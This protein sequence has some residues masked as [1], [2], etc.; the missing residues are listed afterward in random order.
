LIAPA[1]VAACSS[2]SSDE[3]RGQDPTPP[4]VAP[5]D[6]ASLATEGVCAQRRRCCAALGATPGF[7]KAR[8][9]CAMQSL[10]DRMG[11]DIPMDSNAFTNI[12]A[13]QLVQLQQIWK[14]HAIGDAGP[15]A[16]LPEACQ[17]A[18]DR[19]PERARPPSGQAPAK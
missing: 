11:Q 9:L 1:L 8:S 6:E 17:G 12:C 5:P 13:L 7:E 16:P 10:S 14:L 3:R 15:S 4:T 18:P 2:G 19:G